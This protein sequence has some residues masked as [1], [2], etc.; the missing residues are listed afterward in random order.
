[1]FRNN[2]I[3]WLILLTGSL[4]AACGSTKTAPADR[5]EAE[6]G[7]DSSRIV[8]IALDQ[9][10][11]LYTVNERNEILQYRADGS[12][13]FRYNNN[14]LGRLGILDPTNPFAMLAYYPDFQTII[15]L[16]RTLNEQSRIA[17]STLGL[18]DIELVALGNDN[19]IWLYDAVDVQLKKLDREGNISFRSDR[20]NQLLQRI[21]RPDQ[22]LALN[23]R[24]FL[25]DPELGILVFD[26][27]GRYETTLPVLQAESL[28]LVNED[29]LVYMQD[30]RVYSYDL[31]AFEASPV[32]LEIPCAQDCQLRIGK[33][34]IYW[35]EKDRVQQRILRISP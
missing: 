22:L 23:T 18:I 27:F 26:Q 1:M 14:T 21:P 20:L 4:L 25:N 5:A 8:Q 2:N 32:D 16:D 28:Q 34:K 9:L 31:R 24:L 30:G 11:Q 15:L 13:G 12:A 7:G 19:F 6:A 17:L 29:Q 35:L 10:G 33:E 3:L